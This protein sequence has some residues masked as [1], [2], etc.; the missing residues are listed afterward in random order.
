MSTEGTSLRNLVC[1]SLQIPRVKTTTSDLNRWIRDTA[2]TV[3]SLLANSQITP[4]P[5]IRSEDLGLAGDGETDDAFTLWKRLKDMWDA[6][7]GGVFWLEAQPGKSFYFNSSVDV[8]SNQQVIFASP[9]KMGPTGRIRIYGRFKEDPETNL[10]KIRDTIN[11]GDTEIRMAFTDESLASNFEV[12]QRI[13]VRGQSDGSGVSLA[14]ETKTLIAVNTA[15]NILTV[16]SAFEEQYLPTYEAGAFEDNFGITDRSFVTRLVGANLTQDANRGDIEIFVDDISVFNVDDYIFL[17]DDKVPADVSSGT[18][19]ANPIHEETTRIVAIDDVNKKLKLENCLHHSITTAFNAN[20]TVIDM[21]KN[22]QVTRSIVSYAEESAKFVYHAHE[23]DF[24]TSSGFVDCHVRSDG[25]IGNKG[26]GFRLSTGIDNYV[27]LC[28]VTDPDFSGPAEG[29]GFSIYGSTSC[30]IS[31]CYAAGCRHSFIFF[32]GA[33]GNMVEGVISSNTTT[34][35][36]DLHGANEVLN[37]VKDF[38]IVGGDEIAADNDDNRVAIKLG[39]EFHLAG[40][41]DNVIRDG[42]VY[43]YKGVGLDLVPV[44]DGNSIMD[45]DFYN[46]DIG[47]QIVD[48]RRDTTLKTTNNRL[49]RL[50]WTSCSDR[51]MKIDPTV[52]GGTTRVLSDCTMIDCKS[53]DNDRNFNFD[54]CENLTLIRPMVLR[55]R[56]NSGFAYMFD[57]SDITGLKV[58]DALGDGGLRGIRIEDCPS[59]QI[60]DATMANLTDNVVFDDVSGNTGYLLS[61]IDFP[62]VS[63][64][65]FNTSGGGSS[66]GKIYEKIQATIKHVVT[67]VSMPASVTTLLPFDTTTPLISEGEEIISASY[68]PRSPNSLVLVHAYVPVVSTDTATNATLAVFSDSTCVGASGNRLPTTGAAS[69]H[70][71]NAV[72]VI[73]PSDTSTL[74]LSAR[75]GP[76]ASGP[77]L[78]VGGRWGT[79]GHPFFVIEEIQ[80]A[81]S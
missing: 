1:N 7:Y 75:I 51:L 66:G 42:Y 77:T 26:H 80:R 60:I 41:N 46:V 14:K 58:F 53:I 54:Q 64:P 8:R 30:K 22:A 16:D 78:T 79:L 27:N 61:G 34:S 4:L 44:S 69:G 36:I 73:Q 23:C 21:V 3:N 15:T 10:P 5:F 63:S 20:V 19:S 35:D 76:K 81:P 24:A 72:G 2:N 43:N 47:M 45:V 18:T 17:T 70:Q 32:R 55:P 71:L 65:E 50:T 37:L 40:A 62:G 38:L 52:N 49:E 28:S 29:Y 12:G 6:G 59:A 25:G 13:V 33:A 67:S 56:D 39:N 11:V 57:F 9:V 31:N 48:Q 68:T 74:S